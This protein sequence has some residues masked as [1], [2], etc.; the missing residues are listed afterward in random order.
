[1]TRKGVN[2]S[3]MKRAD[4]NFKYE[5]HIRYFCRIVGGG[6]GDSKWLY[7]MTS[8]S[9]AHWGGRRGARRSKTRMGGIGNV[10]VT[11]V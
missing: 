1:M 8:S 10:T 9:V 5:L 11:I 2:T 4:G 7:T 6:S 3:R